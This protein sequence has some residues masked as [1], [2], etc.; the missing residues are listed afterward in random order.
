RAVTSIGILVPLMLTAAAVGLSSL[1]LLL[2]GSPRDISVFGVTADLEAALLA[3]VW[4]VCGVITLV[5]VLA[6]LRTAR[7][8]RQCSPPE[9]RPRAVREP[10]PEDRPSVAVEQSP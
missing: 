7:R 10:V 8:A 6:C 9:Q 2:K 3:L 1:V 5:T 4:G